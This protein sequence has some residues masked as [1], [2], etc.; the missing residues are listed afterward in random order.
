MPTQT[1]TK[2]IAQ[3]DRELLEIVQAVEQAANYGMQHRDEP[4]KV[5]QTLADCEEMLDHV[6]DAS[7]LN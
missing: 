5:E 6:M 2:T 4:A 1:P 3:L 7:I